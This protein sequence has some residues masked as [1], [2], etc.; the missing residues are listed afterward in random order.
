MFEL[1]PERKNREQI[2]HDARFGHETREALSRYYLASIG[3]NEKFRKHILNCADRRTVL[4]YGCG[5]GTHS[6]QLARIAEHVHGIDIS[7][8]AIQL[9]QNRAATMGITNTTFSVMDAENLEFPDQMFDVVCGRA[10]LH[11]LNLRA[12]FDSLSRV[13]KPSGV[14]MFCEPLGHNPAINW[15]RRR[16]PDLRTI[17]EHPLVRDDLKLA[18]VYFRQVAVDHFALVSLAGTLVCSKRGI[19]FRALERIDERLLSIPFLRWWSWISIWTLR[20]PIQRSS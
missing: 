9:A 1:D 8:V 19:M 10:I 4:E 20:E 13:M 18:K 6:F 16:T 3:P 12:S 2:F 5:P 14:A 17:D 7:N 11:H 15:F